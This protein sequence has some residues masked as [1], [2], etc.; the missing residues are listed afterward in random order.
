MKIKPLNDWA[1]VRPSEA[2]SRTA[3][4]IYIP[5]TA[6]E[7][8]A[9]GI[10]EAIGPGAFEDVERSAKKE[11]KKERKFVPT[12]VKPG[13]RVLYERYAGQK[14]TID[15]EELVLVRERSIFGTVPPEA[16]HLKE[17]RQPLMLPRSTSSASSTALAAVKTKAVSVRKELPKTAAGEKA[18]KKGAK[19]AAK[20][21]AAKP[22]P[23]APKK[24]GAG[25]AKKKR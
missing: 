3:G 17:E 12:T 24:T 7:K 4:G 15:G 10:V 18:K 21:A 6:R 8:P 19:K 25:K 9:E 14:M 20:K 13:D 22:R 1:V 23:S 2:A 11:K 16:A 5:E